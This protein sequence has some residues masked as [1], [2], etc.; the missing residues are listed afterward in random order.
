MELGPIGE[1]LNPIRCSPRLDIPES[2]PEKL[3]KW[4]W[5]SDEIQVYVLLSTNLLLLLAVVRRAESVSLC[6]E[7]SG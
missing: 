4:D 3:Y 5:A 2:I 6:R 1:M 7:A